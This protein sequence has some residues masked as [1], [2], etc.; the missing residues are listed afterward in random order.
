VSIVAQQL[1]AIQEE[2][3]AATADLLPD[4]TSLVAVPGVVL[5]SGWNQTVTTIQYIVPVG[6]P[7]ARPD[8]FWADAS[9]RL[10]SGAVPQNAQVQT[11]SFGGPTRLWFSW[12]VAAWGNR[13]TL[14]T[15]L[16]T[17][18]VRLAMLQ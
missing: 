17:V 15:Y 9:L 7:A 12:H 18:L 14:K 16:R 13:D 10:A 2:Y 5:P 4:G 1:E 8:C 3:P 6:Y 11:P